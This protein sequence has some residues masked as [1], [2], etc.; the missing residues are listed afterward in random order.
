MSHTRYEEAMTPAQRPV[1]QDQNPYLP[2]VD[3]QRYR[4][5][6]RIRQLRIA[7]KRHLTADREI[8]ASSTGMK[9]KG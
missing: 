7:L 8:H 6:N 1:L 3:L 2:A 5:L 9:H 4:Q